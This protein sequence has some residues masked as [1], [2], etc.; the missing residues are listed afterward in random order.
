AVESV[1][2]G[3]ADGRGSGAARWRTAS[4]ALLENDCRSRSGRRRSGR[5]ET[6]V[7]H[8]GGE[9][10]RHAVGR[11]RAAVDDLGPGVEGG[12]NV[13]AGRPTARAVAAVAEKIEFGSRPT[14]RSVDGIVTVPP[15]GAPTHRH[16]DAVT[17]R[18]DSS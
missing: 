8:L 7:V 18:A 16:G 3:V 14:V 10:C 9:A 17:R 2:V 5:P 11:V 13:E 6:E 1:Q 4:S 15:V 12:P